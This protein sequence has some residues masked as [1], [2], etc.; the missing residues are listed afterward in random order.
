MD[1]DIKKD[2]DCSSIS[3]TMTESVAPKS[4]KKKHK[5]SKRTLRKDTDSTTTDKS[6]SV[7]TETPCS[8]AN[9]IAK[10]GSSPKKTL[11]KI[12]P[13]KAPSKKES[14]SR[15]PASPP[16]APSFDSTESSPRKKSGHSTSTD[17]WFDASGNY[18]PPSVLDAD[19]ELIGERKPKKKP[20]RDPTP[21]PRRS[22]QEGEHS[23]DRWADLPASP[24]NLVLDRD[25]PMDR[26]LSRKIEKG[27][28]ISINGRYY[29]PYSSRDQKTRDRPNYTS[30]SYPRSSGPTGY[31]RFIQVPS[32]EMAPP[33]ACGRPHGPIR[34]PAPGSNTTNVPNNTVGPN[35][36]FLGGGRGEMFY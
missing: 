36:R 11:R 21:R 24:Q 1:S 25:N 20:T 6:N 16:T 22:Q 7:T 14:R 13:P 34:Y 32:T 9:C 18:N 29:A 28:V 2:I 15:Q 3:T 17:W 5:H 26:S 10:A 8:C 30:I 4:T 33:C 27:E 31:N 23:H 12:K 35:R 19:D